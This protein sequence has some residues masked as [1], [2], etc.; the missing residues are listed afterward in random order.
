MDRPT[1]ANL[2][3]PH[4]WGT[5][6]CLN[7]CSWWTRKYYGDTLTFFALVALKAWLATF[8]TIAI[9]IVTHI[10]MTI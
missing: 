5:K 8:N 4:G 6:A 10:G 3:S 2:N 9:N 7:Q 1:R